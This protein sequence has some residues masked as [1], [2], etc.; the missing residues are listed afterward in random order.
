M[1][2]LP[3]KPDLVISG[4]N[5]GANLGTDLIYSGTAA[6]ARQASLV[7]IPALALSL[8]GRKEFYWDMAV[9]W[10]V[11]HFEDLCRLWSPGTFININIPNSS[12][13]PLGMAHTI[14]ARMR[15]ADQLK[16]FEAP[17]GDIWYFVEYGPSRPDSEEGTDWEAV[18]KN[19]VAVS[20]VLV[21]PAGSSENGGC[22]R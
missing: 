11:E 17:G 14:P 8:A 4:I 21:H 10:T 2:A 13:G 9:A 16:T 15:Y 3:V 19:M 1:G 12:G 20:P 22:K 6:A 7:N 5:R 18:S